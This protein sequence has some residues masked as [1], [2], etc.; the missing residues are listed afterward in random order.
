MYWVVP[1]SIGVCPDS[2]TRV[3]PFCVFDHTPLARW[4]GRERALDA[5]DAMVS[6]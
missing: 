6:S 1:N 2:A 4:F 3:E 5:R